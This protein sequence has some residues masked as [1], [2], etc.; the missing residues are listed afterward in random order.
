MSLSGE[1]QLYSI[2]QLTKEKCTHSQAVTLEDIAPYLGGRAVARIVPENTPVFPFYIPSNKVYYIASGSF[3]I[4][5][6]SL[7]GKNTIRTRKAPSFIGVD[8]AVLSHGSYYA[9]VRTLEECLVL[10]MERDEFLKYIRQDGKLCFEVLHEICEK[11]YQISYRYDQL[12]FF[13]PPTRLMVYILNHWIT[14]GGRQSPFILDTANTRIAEASG[15][16]LRTF[17]RAVSKLKEEHLISVISG[18][19]SVT[20]EQIKKMESLLQLSWEITALPDE[21]S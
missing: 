14:H 13:D 8:H 2:I 18:N 17:Y 6:T 9:H 1:L 16:S 20:A 15:I 10:E 3:S 4:I 5:R 7:E 12:Q 19:I 21:H 11:F